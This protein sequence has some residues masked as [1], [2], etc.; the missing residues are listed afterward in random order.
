MSSKKKVF[1]IEVSVL[2]PWLELQADNKDDISGYFIF[3]SIPNTTKWKKIKLFFKSICNASKN[4]VKVLVRC[5]SHLP[6]HC[7]VGGNGSGRN[8]S[9]CG[10]AL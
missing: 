2:F 7:K 4:N 10:D 5:S 3:R 9:S 1:F 8:Y 6:G